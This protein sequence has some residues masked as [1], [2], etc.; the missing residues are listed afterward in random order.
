MPHR[1]PR[2]S[3]V[4]ERRKRHTP[5]FILAAATV[6]APNG[7]IELEGNVRMRSLEDGSRCYMH[8]TRIRITSDGNLEVIPPPASST[9]SSY[10]GANSFPITPTAS[11]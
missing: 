2:G 11:H 6:D 4:A 7:Y 8:S 3:P 1:G 10:G 5:A 9:P